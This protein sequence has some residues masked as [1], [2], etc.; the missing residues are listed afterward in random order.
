MLQHGSHMVKEI[1]KIGNSQGI[2]LDSAIL[3]SMNVRLGDQVSIEVHR[4]GTMTITPLHPV[5]SDE[6]AANTAKE[7]IAQND[8]LFR[9]LS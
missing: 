4:G 5:I 9:R 6:Q 1:R 7:I 8:E 3:E 2:I